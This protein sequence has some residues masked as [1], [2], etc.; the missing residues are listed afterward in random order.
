MDWPFV[1]G[2]NYDGC[3]RETELVDSFPPDG[4]RVLWTRPLGVGYSGFTTSGDRLFT[5]C[6][7]LSGQYVVCLNAATGETLWEY[8][9]GLPYESAG[10]YPGPRATPTIENDCVFFA[11]PNGLVGCLE[12]ST[13]RPIWSL[14]IFE[15]FDVEPVEFGYSCSPV[16]VQ[17]KVL[18]PVGKPNASVVALDASTGRVVWRAGDDSISHVPVLPIRWQGRSL[19]LCYLRNVIAAFDIESGTLAF[20]IPRSVG[21]DEHAAW[22]IYK[23]PH[24][25]I[26]GP[27][28]A[29][30]ELIELTVEKPGYRTVWQS[31]LMSNDVCSS[32]LVDGYLYGFDIRDQQ[33][34]LHRP[35]RGQVRCLD[36]LT[37]VERWANGSESRTADVAEA[38]QGSGGISGATPPIGHASVIYADGKLIFFNDRGELILA[39]AS[40]SAYEELGRVQVL[41]GELCWTPPTLSHGRVFVRN[42]SRAACLI[43]SRA[44]SKPDGSAK[45]T[46]ADIPQSTYRDWA[47][48]LLPVEP[49]FA[50]DLP[51]DQELWQSYVVCLAGLFASSALA[52]IGHS[53]VSRIFRAENLNGRNTLRAGLMLVLGVC[54]TTVLS[55]YSQQFIFTW[56]LSLFGLFHVTFR[57]P[58][59]PHSACNHPIPPPG[60]Q[61]EGSAHVL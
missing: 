34:K 35:S 23:E 55:G 37:G 32:V 22:P 24:V 28:R 57:H 27:F 15:A 53:A 29:G 42:H 47:A 26:T 1:R 45:L 5:Q 50:M 13:G 16:V 21:Y 43:L 36:F 40:P 44:G 56:P 7:A 59:S 8:R 20:R 19:A 46:V 12:I 51:T 39:R 61:C 49:E 48:L 41:G 38:P 18:L 30:C 54:G 52:L 31:K 10:L 25:W 11:A 9:Y 17:G 2:P 58:R 3:S 4:P 14:N 33:T 60:S 6:Q